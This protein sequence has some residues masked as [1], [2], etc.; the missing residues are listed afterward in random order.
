MSG[1][2][3]LSLVLAVVITSLLAGCNPEASGFSLPKGDPSQGEVA[4]SN[5]R[6]NHC[7]SIAGGTRQ[8]ADGHETISFELGGYVT[9]VRTYGDLVTSIINPSHR[10]SGGRN[11]GP[12]ITDSGESRMVD[13]NKIMTVQELIDLSAY[14]RVTYRVVPP[15]S[16]PVHYGI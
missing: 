11:V 12:H 8:A 1:T 7:H 14:L 15:T 6:C 16:I 10:I 2:K 5:L 3:V 4:F 9:K 13:I